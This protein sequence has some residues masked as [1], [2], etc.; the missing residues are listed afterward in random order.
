MEPLH[1]FLDP[2]IVLYDFLCKEFDHVR[3]NLYQCTHLKCR[4]A[5][6]HFVFVGYLKE[7]TLPFPAIM[8]PDN[9]LSKPMQC[10][11][12]CGPLKFNPQSTFYTCSVCGGNFMKHPEWRV[13]ASPEDWLCQD[14]RVLRFFIQR[15]Q[16]AATAVR[17]AARENPNSA[18]LKDLVRRIDRAERV[19]VTEILSHCRI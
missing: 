8:Y 13:L 16:A 1:G 4:L 5:Y 14:P 3:N 7:P 9:I 18:E 10:K 11:P 19:F 12:R 2:Q 6:S 15:A 17:V